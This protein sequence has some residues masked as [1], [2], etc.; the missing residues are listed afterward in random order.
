MDLSLTNGGIPAATDERGGRF[1]F[2]L[3]R[4]RAPYNPD[5]W[6]PISRS[7]SL[8]RGLRSHI[9]VGN[10]IASLSVETWL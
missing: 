2:M 4:R 7:D 10:I 9:G 1:R 3:I 5:I 8:C 6:T